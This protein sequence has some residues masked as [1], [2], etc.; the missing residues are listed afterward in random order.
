M[1][2]PD[3]LGFELRRGEETPSAKIVPANPG[4]VTKKL[5]YLRCAGFGFWLGARREH[6][7]HGPVTEE[8]QRQ[9]PNPA[10]PSGRHVFLCQP[11][12]FAPDRPIKGM[13]VAHA[14]AGTKIHCRAG[15][16]ISLSQY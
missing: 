1:P 11:S 2:M 3:A 9:K 13:R 8:Q 10:Q 4:T 6:V 16:A 14:L 15:I 7:R 12:L 5:R